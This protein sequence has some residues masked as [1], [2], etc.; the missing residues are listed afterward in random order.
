MTGE[1]CFRGPTIMLGYLNQSDA[2]AETID[3]DGWLKSGKLKKN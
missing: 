1:L 3:N 2:T